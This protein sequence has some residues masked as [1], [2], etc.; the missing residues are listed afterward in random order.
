VAADVDSCCGEGGICNPTQRAW[1]FGNRKVAPSRGRGRSFMSCTRG[2][3]APADMWTLVA[4]TAD[5][6]C[7]GAGA[8]HA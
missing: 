2:E 6:C 5:S 8:T 7:T 3:L 4:E 1:G